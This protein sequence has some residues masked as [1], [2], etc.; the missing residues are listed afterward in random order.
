[1]SG[2]ESNSQVRIS[3]EGVDDGL[4]VGGEHGA[5]VAVVLE[6]VDK[7]PLGFCR[8][9]RSDDNFDWKV[10]RVSGCDDDIGGSRVYREGKILSE[11]TRSRGVE[12]ISP[13]LAN[14]VGPWACAVSRNAHARVNAPTACGIGGTSGAS[15]DAGA[16]IVASASVNA[17]CSS[18]RKL[19][20]GEVAVSLQEVSASDEDLVKATGGCDGDGEGRRVGKTRYG[21]SGISSECPG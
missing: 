7:I 21:K 6:N 19:V 12:S 3:G 2:N 10:E 14:S 15:R 9:T 13:V 8:I 4:N 17:E 20:G 11:T 1:M 18:D 5:N 16:C